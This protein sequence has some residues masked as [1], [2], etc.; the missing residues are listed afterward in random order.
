MTNVT[1]EMDDDGVGSP[2][3]AL[4]GLILGPVLAILLF[5]FAKPEGLTLQGWSVV[6]LLVLMVFW[7]IFEAIPV[8]ATA[9]LP[10]IFL[11]L[12]TGMKPVDAAAPYADPLIYLFIGG[13]ILAAAVERSGLHK[14]IALGLLGII[15]TKSR[16]LLAGM[17]ICSGLLS[18]W[19]SNTATTLMLVPIALGI[20]KALAIDQKIDSNFGAALVVGVAWAATIGGI[21][22]PIGSPPNL[23][24]MAYLQKNGLEISFSS[25]M[26]LG[27]PLSLSMLL[28]CYF[29]LSR[30][31]PKD[32]GPRV[33]I[34]KGLIKDMTSSLGRMRKV[35]FRVLIIFGLV[36]L[37]WI[38]RELII[39]IPAFKGLTDMQIAIA[40]ALALFLVPSGEKPGERLLDWTSAERIPW[41]IALLFGAGL[42]L[43]AAMES[44][45]VTLW[46]TRQFDGL[47]G[48][49]PLLVLV[50]IVAITVLISEFASNLATLVVFLPVI[51]AVAAITGLAPLH[52]VFGACMGASLAFMMPI[53]TPPNAIAY[54]TGL[55]SLPRMLRLGFMLNVAGIALT[56]IIV[57]S[58]GAIVLGH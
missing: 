28:A 45:G 10:L 24:A 14:R 29:I 58:F 51:S 34:I 40:G 48:L 9:L 33:E 18:M 47:G 50:L 32:E 2:K 31:L 23:V 55:M 49:S 44:Q 8:A 22:T 7:W 39:K 19:I 3:L 57:E 26:M 42:T 35:E 15:G 25:W 11:P 56:V 52:L 53:G 21:A 27:V 13:F 5:M 41:G 37:A 54:G 12:F 1:K 36:A 43:A 38:F 6:C 46:L 20:A 4:A 17:I 30:S 16:A